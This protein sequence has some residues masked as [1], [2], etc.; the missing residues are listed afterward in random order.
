MMN[1]LRH[2][3]YMKQMSMQ[4]DAYEQAGKEIYGNV[5]MV[6]NPPHYNVS[7]VE[8]IDAIAASTGEGFE[9]YLQGNIMKYLWR[10]RYKNGT[11]DLKK[12]SWY[13]DKLIYEV[14]GVYD[15]K[16]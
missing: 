14:E 3:E 4:E 7:G 15:D 6:N 8:C 9:F 13:L 12:A 2:E 5:D 16:S 11:Q 1:Q 10:Y